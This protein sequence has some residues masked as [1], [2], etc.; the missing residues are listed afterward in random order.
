MKK[1]ILVY[2]T[3]AGLI[4]GAMF[5]IGAPLYDKGIITFDNGMLVGYTS[6]VIALSLVFFGIKSY[7]DSHANGV[8]T[9]GKAFKIGMLVTLVAS[10]VYAISWEVA[11]NTVSKGYSE[12]MYT[13]QIEKIKQEIKDE[14]ELKAQITKMEEFK[15]MY[16]NP[17]IRFGITLFEIFPVGLIISLVSAGLLRKKEFM[18]GSSI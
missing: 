4:V 9:F 1:I 6:M 5:F 16:Q 17:F 10:V 7:R 3:I 11:Y 13:H 18:A 8:I 15:V 14:T 2:G 12:A